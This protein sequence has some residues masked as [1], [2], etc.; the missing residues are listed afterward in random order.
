[1][2]ICKTGIMDR[3]DPPP[4]II[5]RKDPPPGIMDRKDPPPAGLSRF[6]RVIVDKAGVR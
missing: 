5:D 6:M 1:V 4:G 2:L 3:K